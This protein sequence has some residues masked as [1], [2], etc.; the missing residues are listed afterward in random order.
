V[1]RLKPTKLHVRWA[2]GIGPAGP[3]VPR[4]YTLTHSDRT[5]DMYLTIGRTHDLNQISG[6][7][8]RLMRDEVLAAWGHQGS[9]PVLHVHCHVSGGLILGLPRWRDAILCHEMPLVLETLRYGDR[10]LYEACPELDRV[11]I[12]VHFHARQ[13][14][15]DRVES[16]G[17]PA[18]YC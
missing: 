11:P 16:W 8:T 12:R 7:Y 4:C 10:S 18:D 3:V 13:A 5:G 15:Y 1:N 2:E 6:W 9:G 14:R 17:V